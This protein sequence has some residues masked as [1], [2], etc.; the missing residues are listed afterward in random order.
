MSDDESTPE[1]VVRRYLRIFETGDRAELERVVAPDVEIWG[2]GR[3][4]TGIDFPLASIETPG[5]SGCRLEIVEL[6]AAD[7][8][9][10]VYFIATYRHDASDRDVRQ[11]GMKMYQVRDG[12]IVR[13][14][15]ETDLH[16]L[17]RDLGKIEG[18][19]DFL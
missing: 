13:F 19:I 6:F 18:T 10:V 1:A 11:S 2:A 3:H 9:V 15:G 12:R 14:W 4:V 17:L 8:R 5:L 7:D 16:G